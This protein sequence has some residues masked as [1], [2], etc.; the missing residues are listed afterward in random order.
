VSKPSWRRVLGSALLAAG[1]AALLAIAVLLRFASINDRL[2]HALILDPERT[3]PN[4]R[5]VVA[6]ADGHVLYVRRVEDGTIPFVVKRGVPVPV[7]EHLKTVPTHPFRR[8][9]LVG[10]Y[11]NTNGVHVNRAP[12][13]GVL[14]HQTVW[15]GPH[16][17]MTG[18]E[19]GLV[20]RQMLPGFVTMRKL[21]GLDPYAIEDD[22]DYV[23]KSARETLE[24]EGPDGRPVYVVRIADYFVGKILTWVHEGQ[25]I[26]R[27]QRIGMITWGSQTDVLF[28]EAPGMTLVVEPGQYVHGGESVLAR[29]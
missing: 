18:A 2:G 13:D 17:D 23:L 6:P 22:A 4:G 14:T 27:G 1:L 5:V 15:N 29:Y 19:T 11:M 3:I 16:M 10:I 8:G 7:A 12:D 20:L 24:F 21:L 9:Y 26:E 25:R 28:E